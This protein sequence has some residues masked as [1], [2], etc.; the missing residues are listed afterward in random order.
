MNYFDFVASE[1]QSTRPKKFSLTWFCISILFH[2]LILLLIMSYKFN[3]F[4]QEIPK[5]IRPDDQMVLWT[6][7]PKMQPNNPPL[8]TQQ[9]AE[10]PPAKQQPVKEEQEPITETKPFNEDGFLKNIP[11]VI[12]GKQGIDEHNPLGE[13]S[14]VQSPKN[15]DTSQQDLEIDTSQEN[16]IESDQIPTPHNKPLY[17][18]SPLEIKR[19]NFFAY[20]TPE[21]I[22]P[23]Q[24]PN[25]HEPSYAH[26]P[27]KK[28]TKKLHTRSFKNLGF[29]HNSSAPTFGNSAH[30]SIAGYSPDIPTGDELKYVTYV[31]QLADTIVNSV[32]TNPRKR[33]I[34]GLSHERLGLYM[35]VDR[36]GN[37]LDTRMVSPSRHEIINI[38][39]IESVQTAGL[40]S[41]LPRFITKDTFE[42]TWTIIM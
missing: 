42:I 16:Q 3:I 10:E 26:V 31:N 13:E 28:L 18:T 8:T 15:S 5:S 24:H 17:T 38:V 23:E 20:S 11:M 30:L 14:L 29:G 1:P 21:N 22:V 9:P 12:P 25:S 36:N 33:L 34:Y 41:K 2:L 40:F 32:N 35:K 7:S 4:E 6:Q 19:G 27:H 39:L 37:L